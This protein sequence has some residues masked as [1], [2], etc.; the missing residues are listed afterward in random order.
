MAWYLVKHQDSFT[1]TLKFRAKSMEVKNRI[2]Y[3]EW[4]EIGRWLI[5]LA[6]QLSFR[7]HL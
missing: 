4:S 3:S 2:S 1:F 5:V 6:F 7:V